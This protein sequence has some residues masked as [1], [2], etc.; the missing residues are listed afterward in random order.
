MKVRIEDFSK[1]LSEVLDCE[2]T[3][4]KL[5][6]KPKDFDEWDSLN[7][8]FLIVKLESFYKIKFNTSSIQKWTCVGD[9][10]NDIN[11]II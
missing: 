4:L 1:L 11:T 10:I 8:V 9:I 5:T 6:S 7:Q 3:N 2:I